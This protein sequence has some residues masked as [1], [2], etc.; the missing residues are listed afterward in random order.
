MNLDS[1]LRWVL[2]AASVAVLGSA[3]TPTGPG[4]PPGTTTTT[5]PCTDDD[6]ALPHF[7]G[8]AGPN[9]VGG[10]TAAYTVCPGTSDWFMFD[11]PDSDPLA[12]TGRYET[13]VRVTTLDTE[14]PPVPEE[15]LVEIRRDHQAGG[16]GAAIML[17][18]RLDPVVTGQFLTG[19]SPAPDRLRVLVKVTGGADTSGRYFITADGIPA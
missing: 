18:P 17:A 11:V 2:V 15:Y 6:T 4:E 9:L 19:G 13:T 16:L 7:L 1:K 14:V 5:V 12:G 3:C 8:P 10:V